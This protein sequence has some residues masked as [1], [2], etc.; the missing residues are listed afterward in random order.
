M[1]YVRSAA[2]ADSE[3]TDVALDSLFACANGYLAHYSVAHRAK[4]AVGFPVSALWDRLVLAVTRDK[5]Q[6][7]PAFT[8]WGA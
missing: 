5:S 2:R 6:Y 1:R 3:P 7:R 4:L 8:A